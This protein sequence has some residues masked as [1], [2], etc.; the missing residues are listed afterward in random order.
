MVS[1]SCISITCS[2]VEIPDLSE[3]INKANAWVVLRMYRKD[4]DIVASCDLLG[5]QFINFLF[6]LVISS[7]HFF[8]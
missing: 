4:L 5:V 1:N 8:I 6:Y 7:G 2:D 3:H